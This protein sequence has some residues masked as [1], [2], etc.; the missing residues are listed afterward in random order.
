MVVV[1]RDREEIK[2]GDIILEESSVKGGVHFHHPRSTIPETLPPTEAHPRFSMTRGEREAEREKR[3]WIAG[4][5]L[6]H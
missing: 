3:E 6:P 2:E 1:T 5:P 4:Q